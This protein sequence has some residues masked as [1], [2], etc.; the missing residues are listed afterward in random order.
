MTEESPV[1]KA[2][3]FQADASG[4]TQAA[5]LHKL[6]AVA[7]AN[8]FDLLLCPEL[9]MS[10][11]NIESDF[12]QL[13]EPSD[14]PF[15]DGVA[16]IA[17]KTNTAIAYGY[18]ELAAGGLYNSALCIDSTGSTV[19][20]QRKLVL[21]PGFETDTFTTGCG[22]SQFQLGGMSM[23]LLICYD[24]E[25]PEAARAAAVAGSDVILAPTAL[26]AEWDVVANR[27]VP[28]R[29]FE[30]GIYVMYANHAGV[31]NG[32]TYLGRS[33]IVGPDGVDLA[34]AG[35]A[36]QVITADLTSRAVQKA[37]QRIPY[38]QDLPQL[39]DRI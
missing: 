1:L 36:E 21:P 35:S 26:G 9:F 25:F 24:L 38:F 34:R 32:K 23:A 30:N 22:I 18:P 20:V 5:R 19:A 28:A 3:I 37:Q 39:R 8:N 2:A 31:E 33:C 11:Y 7:S 13:A 14:G 6:G 10:G 29:A 4:L 17:R 15:A 27:L 12:R 16:K